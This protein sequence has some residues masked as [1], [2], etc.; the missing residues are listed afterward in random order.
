MKIDDIDID[1]NT[2]LFVIVSCIALTALAWGI[3]TGYSFGFESA[4]E[5]YK[6]ASFK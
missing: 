4:K 5:I 3:V 2:V 6:G 1:P